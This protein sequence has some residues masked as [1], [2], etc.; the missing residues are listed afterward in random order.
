MNDLS[1][2]Q[3]DP[4][5]AEFLQGIIEDLPNEEYH[6]G[7]GLS[8]SGIK[9]MLQ[10]PLHYYDKYVK[11]DREENDS[12]PTLIQGSAYH[13][14]V[15]EPASFNDEFA[16]PLDAEDYPDALRT[17]ADMTDRL[18]LY[19]VPVKGKPKKEQLIEMVTEAD[20]NAIFWDQIV[21][22]HES[23]SK[24]KT[25]LTLKQL[26]TVN[27]MSRALNAHPTIP[28]LIGNGKVEVSMYW[29]DEATGVLCKIRPDLY[30]NGVMIA[31]LKSTQDASPEGFPKSVYNY[32]YHISAAYYLDGY[33][34]VTGDDLCGNFIFIAQESTSPYAAAP[35]V[36]SDEALE[37]GRR[38]Y[39]R[40]LE[41]FA[42]CSQSGNWPGYSPKIQPISLPAWAFR[43]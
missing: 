40:A 26:E 34:A 13:S 23:E 36:I 8:S 28:S 1:S 35:Y 19:G 5:S 10:S 9:L 29:T 21:K 25:M 30:V 20:P 12:T 22:A 37:V 3:L 16:L 33:K 2:N 32:G 7:P 42:E 43:K 39:R 38:E 11:E 4:Q 14:L 27:E 31:D 18:K 41:M 17:V 24:G 15:L 6:H